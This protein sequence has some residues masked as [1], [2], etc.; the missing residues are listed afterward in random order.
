MMFQEHDAGSGSDHPNCV[1]GQDCNCG[2][3]GTAGL[4]LD[5]Q[6]NP[7]AQGKPVLMEQ[8]NNGP[9][10]TICLETMSRVARALPE[11][12]QQ[13]PAVKSVTTD[14]VRVV[15]EI[16]YKRDGHLKNVTMG[17]LNDALDEYVTHHVQEYVR[18]TGQQVA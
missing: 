1:E 4:Q 14:V 12:L 8:K 18:Q 16:F 5:A 3:H 2:K 9:L 17:D 6:V 7:A 15:V 11:Y 13:G 10:D